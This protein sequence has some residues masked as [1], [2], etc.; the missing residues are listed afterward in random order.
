MKRP[1]IL[2]GDEGSLMILVIGLLGIGLLAL[3][4]LIDT[5]GMLLERRSLA[6][7]ADSSAIAGAQAIDV[8]RYYRSGFT[9]RDALRLAPEQVV[10]AVRSHLRQSGVDQ[11]HDG[12]RV[13]EITVS[14]DLVRVRLSAAVHLPF[15]SS[16]VNR[17]V[18][19]RA[20]SA[21]RMV[22]GN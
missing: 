7:A 11:R 20:M 4:V 19:V 3:G 21:A 6:A 2:R 14:G 18:R 9:T 8:Q 22:V 15:S 16:L 1:R 13:E 5:S 17:P 12:L 10:R